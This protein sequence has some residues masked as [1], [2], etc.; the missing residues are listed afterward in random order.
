MLSVISLGWKRD[1]GTT[2]LRPCHWPQDSGP[3]EAGICLPGAADELPERAFV[4][5][6]IAPIYRGCWTKATGVGESGSG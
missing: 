3:S 2:D 5:W 4:F 1:R 6:I